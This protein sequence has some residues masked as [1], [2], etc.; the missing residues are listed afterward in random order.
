MLA[1]IIDRLTSL[2]SKY[3]VIS[4]FIPVLMFAF[5]SGS[6]LYHDLSWFREWAK[7]EISGTV[8]AFDAG[9]IFIGLSIVAYIFSTVNTFLREIL[10]G[11]HLLEI[12]SSL[13]SLFLS[14]QQQKLT[15]IETAYMT[16]RKEHGTFVRQKLTWQEHLSDAANEGSQGHK[17]NDFNVETSIV[18]EIVSQLKTSRA[19]ANPLSSADMEKAVS[20][21]SEELKS[22]D[23]SVP[24]LEGAHSLQ[25]LRSELLILMDYAEDAWSSQ[26]LRS[27][28]E[29][30][31]RF[32]VSF[33]APTAMGNVALSMQGYALTRYQLNLEKFWGDL[34]AILQA[35]K[36]FYSQL[37]DA[38][39]QLDFL[40]TCCW[41]SVLV[42]IVCGSILLVKGQSVTLFLAVAL[43]GPAGAYFFYFLGVKNYQGFAELVRIGVDLYRFQLLDS[44]HVS[45]PRTA[46]DER[47]TWSTL[48]RLSYF[49]AEGTEFSYK[50]DAKTG[51]Q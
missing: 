20:Q 18:A 19:Q 46:R 44:L 3:L 7:P 47:V 9:A 35:N 51:P 24:D 38:K 31:S 2:V 25:E 15:T 45:R 4:S 43:G 49:G 1:S 48:Q 33:V 50:P 40:V 14:R 29:R 28:N 42:T 17:G 22:H 6:I 12:W 16:A 5:I 13:K 10:E 8:K 32:G 41:L 27:F 34:Q 26:E 39:A 11:K 21:L 37:Q 30:Q 23:E 36:D